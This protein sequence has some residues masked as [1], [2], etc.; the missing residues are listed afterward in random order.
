MLRNTKAACWYRSASNRPRW[1]DGFTPTLLTQPMHTLQRCKQAYTQ[2]QA[3]DGVQ[4][5]MAPHFYHGSC[6]S[7]YYIM[8][9]DSLYFDLKITRYKL[10]QENGLACLSMH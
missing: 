2:A 5:R 8:I 3:H 7:K 6:M 1:D 10:D 4:A 9:V